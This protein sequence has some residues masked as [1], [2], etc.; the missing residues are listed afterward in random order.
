MAVC[1]GSG[2]VIISSEEILSR[3]KSFSKAKPERSCF[4]ERTRIFPFLPFIGG[5]PKQA[6]RA[7]VTSSFLSRVPEYL[8]DILAES[9]LKKCGVFN[10]S[11]V[12]TLIKKLKFTKQ[13]SETDN[14]SLT[15]IISTQ[16]LY[17][18]YI[19]GNKK[20]AFKSNKKKINIISNQANRN[21]KQTIKV[22]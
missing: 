7:P 17:D 4:P 18:Q 6:Y 22:K 20:P 15:S 12:Q 14:M 8:H 19:T 11:S 16:I 3:T 21:N 10:P 13:I 1:T 5:R 9:Q 2:I